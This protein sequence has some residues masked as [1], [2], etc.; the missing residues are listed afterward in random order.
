M[1]R[2]WNL[3]IRRGWVRIVKFRVFVLLENWVWMGR[4]ELVDI[5]VC[6]YSMVLVFW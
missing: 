3:R 4:G 1:K 6:K 2:K 5:C